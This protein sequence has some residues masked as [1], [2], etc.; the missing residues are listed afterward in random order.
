MGITFGIVS[1][2]AIGHFNPMAALGHE[3]QQRNHR[4]VFL[5]IP[6]WRSRVEAGGFDFYPIGE[7]EYPLGSWETLMTNLSNSSSLPNLLYT[8][9]TYKKEA[10]II[11]RDVPVAIE[12]E[13]INALI[14]DQSEMAGA[15]VGEYKSLPFVSVCCALAINREPDIPPL[16]TSW[17][18]K[19][20]WWGRQR[21]RL[22]Y[23][24][25]D[26]LC[27]PIYQVLH[28]Q[29][30]HWGLPLKK[31]FD[32]M[33]SQLAQISQQIPEF[34]FPRS[35]LPK[36]FHY[37]GPLRGRSVVKAEF[38]FDRLDGRPLIYASLGTIQNRRLD[39][40]Q[41]IAAACADLNVQLVIAHGGVL[42]S[43]VS[44]KLPGSPL[45]V[46]Y[47][48]QLEVIRHAS[49]VSHLANKIYYCKPT[50]VDFEL[51]DFNQQQEQYNQT[52]AWGK[53]NLDKIAIDITTIPDS[54]LEIK[55]PQS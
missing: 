26:L 42:P 28:R 13:G 54:E 11:F 41:I 48:P 36:S 55:L 37:T 12:R 50:V 1:P 27:Y 5:L 7:A 23:A 35:Q 20:S 16:L 31:N 4:V 9:N 25:L 39:I 15:I 19:P 53:S 17:N 18:Y 45:V 33:V 29:Q 44:E 47:A 8:I 34:D 22:G 52:I 10:E 40:F 51:L 3:L 14:V 2:P 38:P 43:E 24:T 30:K 49:L 46:E 6:D 21:N 32:E